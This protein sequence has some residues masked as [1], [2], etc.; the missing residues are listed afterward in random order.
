[1][2]FKDI[3]SSSSIHGISRLL[4]IHNTV[5]VEKI[6]MVVLFRSLNPDLSPLRTKNLRPPG[7]S[8]RFVHYSDLLESDLLGA[9]SRNH[10]QSVFVVHFYDGTFSI[11]AL[12]F[13]TFVFVQAYAQETSFKGASTVRTK[14][15]A[16]S[17]SMAFLSLLH[18]RTPYQNPIAR[19]SAVSVV[20]A[21]GVKYRLMPTVL[22][23]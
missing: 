22:P 9:A 20:P 12:P 13:R 2:T 5:S 16:S 23:K 18:C 10:S 6:G 14:I 4:N 11:R 1:L 17:C 15:V 8:P 21:V 3:E 19:I 7:T